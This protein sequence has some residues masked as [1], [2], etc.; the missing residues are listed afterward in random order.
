ML[1]DKKPQVGS[2]IVNPLYTQCETSQA[3][4]IG[5]IPINAICVLFIILDQ[6]ATVKLSFY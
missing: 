3:M 5:M 6:I 1:Q 4:I 2:N